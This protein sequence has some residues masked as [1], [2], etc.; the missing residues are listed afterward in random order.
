[1]KTKCLLFAAVLC[2]AAVV[3]LA[4]ASPAAATSGCQNTQTSSSIDGN[5]LHT[6][7][8]WCWTGTIINAVVPNGNDFSSSTRTTANPWLWNQWAK[9]AYCCEQTATYY[10]DRW[11]QWILPA[12]G[13]P[14]VVD[15]V[16]NMM[17]FH[18]D[19][20]YQTNPGNW[21]KS[22]TITYPDC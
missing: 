13:P 15:C 1:M 8:D 18:G 19:G 12:N 7:I 10:I 4:S 20:S 22:G 17:T 3:A 5:S 21:T 11:S 2:L 16:R 6:S 14:W 9:N